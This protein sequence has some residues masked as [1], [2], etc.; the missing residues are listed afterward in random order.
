MGWWVSVF[1]LAVFNDSHNLFQE[2]AALRA[3][4]SHL[5]H[6]VATAKVT[7]GDLT[8]RCEESRKEA[9]AA[10]KARSRLVS[11][12]FCVR[13]IRRDRQTYTHALSLGLW[14]SLFPSIPP[15]LYLA[16][17][18]PV[19]EESLLRLFVHLPSAFMLALLSSVT[20]RPPS[21]G[22]CPARE[23]GEAAE[24]LGGRRG[25]VRTPEDP[26]RGEVEGGE[27]LYVLGSEKMSERERVCV[28]ACIYRLL[29]LLLI[30]VTRRRG[31][32]K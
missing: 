14:L 21:V 20:D 1:A 4:N 22:I 8:L 30:G 17:L 16:L 25:Q 27:C 15:S 23:G 29:C 9:E 2:L 11:F 31:C 6:D 18:P 3:E 19:F 13:H 12:R 26:R 10:K 5:K 32:G 28:C 24:G 7:I